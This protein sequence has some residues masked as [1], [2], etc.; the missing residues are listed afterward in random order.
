[1]FKQ[2]QLLE[3]LIPFEPESYVA[4]L[5]LGKIYI[6]KENYKKTKQCFEQAA[7][8]KSEKISSKAK[9]MVKQSEDLQSRKPYLEDKKLN[10]FAKQVKQ[11]YLSRVPEE[12]SLWE[13]MKKLEYDSELRKNITDETGL[14]N[15]K[16]LARRIGFPEEENL[17]FMIIHLNLTK[18]ETHKTIKEKRT[19]YKRLCKHFEIEPDKEFISAQSL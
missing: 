15:Y 8:S 14:L 4:Y 10:D 3:T 19:N 2:N 13:K 5:D 16:T 11:D 12:S 17:A 7:K 18:D 1:M 9:T 6:R